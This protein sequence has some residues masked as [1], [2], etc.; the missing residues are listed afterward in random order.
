LVNHSRARSCG[1]MTYGVVAYPKR[2]SKRRQLGH[3]TPSALY[4]VAFIPPFPLPRE[5]PSSGPLG[6]GLSY[7]N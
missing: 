4:A 1:Y 7:I 5:I 2:F 6:Y 3:N